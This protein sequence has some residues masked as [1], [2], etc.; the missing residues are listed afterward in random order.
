[1]EGHRPRLHAQSRVGSPAEG[2]PHLQ[3]TPSESVVEKIVRDY[4]LVLL[5]D[6]PLSAR[7]SV[8]SHGKLLD[9]QL[10]EEEHG[11]ELRP[12][13][14]EV[15]VEPSYEEEGTDG[16]D[17]ITKQNSKVL[18]ATQRLTHHTRYSQTAH[19]TTRPPPRLDG[20]RPQCYQNGVGTN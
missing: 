19:T 4:H 14:E 10:T 6:C 11:E 3:P 1:M 2:R 9:V 15:P 8:R 17:K 20:S 16:N 18:G 7:G 5:P 13:D 12:S